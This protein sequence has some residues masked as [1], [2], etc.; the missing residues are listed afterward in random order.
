[1]YVNERGGRRMEGRESESER[2]KREREK[3]K[4][5]KCMC[6]DVRAVAI[7]ATCVS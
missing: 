3:R 5:K 7:V 1:M 2:G 6:P 4:K